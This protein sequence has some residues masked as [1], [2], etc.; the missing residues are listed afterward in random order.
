MVVA[1]YVHYYE[2]AKLTLGGEQDRSHDFRTDRLLFG[3]AQDYEASE[4]RG[5]IDAEAPEEDAPA[6]RRPEAH[7]GPIGSGEKVVADEEALRRLLAGCP[8]MLATAMEGA[9][10]ARAATNH[11]DRSLAFLEVRG[12][13]DYADH[14]GSSDH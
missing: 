13:S 5:G 4:W 14:H 2:P 6:A 12:I 9:G 3:R 10:V 1:N 11:G 7:F 8:K